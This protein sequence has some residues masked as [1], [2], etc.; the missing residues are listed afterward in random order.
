MKK[1][2]S[3]ITHQINTNRK[4]ALAIFDPL[5]VKT[6]YAMSVFL[7]GLKR[8]A[9]FESPSAFSHQRYQSI[10]ASTESFLWSR[11]LTKNYK[12]ARPEIL[13]F[14][15]NHAVEPTYVGTV[16]DQYIAKSSSTRWFD[17]IRNDGAL[18]CVYFAS[19]ANT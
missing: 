18:Q 9:N 19:S 6:G 2:W 4:R 17:T 10:R 1:D 12:S 15:L 5:F 14:C 11:G 8:Y 13:E 7:S 16:A 3:G